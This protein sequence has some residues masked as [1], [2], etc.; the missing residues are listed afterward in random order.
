[1]LKMKIIL[2]GDGSHTLFVPELNEHYH[3]THGAI[4]ESLHI[5]IG[6][7]LHRITDIN[8]DISILEVGFGTGLNVLLTC[9]EPAVSNRKIHYVTFEPFPLENSLVKELNYHSRLDNPEAF[10]LFERI[11]QAEWNQVVAITESFSLSKINK[12]IQDVVTETDHYNLIY[13]DAFS[14]VVQPEMWT[15]DVFQ[16]LFQSLKAGGILVTYCC[17]GEVKR[18]LKLASFTLEKL[19]GPPGKR[20]ILRATKPVA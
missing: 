16:K 1:M 19:S 7:G 18:S 11:H 12:R 13:F 20:E 5:F 17:K 8:S 4:R 14:P 2:S 9:L 3:S 15:A 6:A 10:L